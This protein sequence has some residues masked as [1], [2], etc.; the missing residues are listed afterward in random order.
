[1]ILRR[2]VCDWMHQYSSAFQHLTFG[3]EILFLCT[4]LKAFRWFAKCGF[5]PATDII[6]I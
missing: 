5:F 2:F 3:F 4:V 1:M 6:L